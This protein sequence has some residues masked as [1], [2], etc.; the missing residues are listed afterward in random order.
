VTIADKKKVKKNLQ[1]YVNEDMVDFVNFY[2]QTVLD[3]YNEKKGSQ[4]HVEI[5][6]DLGHVYPGIKGF[7]DAAIIEPFGTLHL[8]DLKYGMRKVE[9]EH[10]EQGMFYALGALDVFP[11][12]IIEE[13]NIVIVQPRIS[14]FPS[15]WLISAEELEA[16]GEETLAPAAKAAEDSN[17]PLVT[18]DHCE[19]FFCKALKFATCPATESKVNEVIGAD[20]TKVSPTEL[21]LPDPSDLSSKDVSNILNV[22]GLITA[23]LKNVESMAK[24]RLLAGVPVPGRKLVAGKKG[25]RKW[26]DEDIAVGD[27]IEYAK[28]PTSLYEPPKLKS[29]AKME[30]IPEFKKDKDVKALIGKLVTSA[31]G[32]PTMVSDSDPRP[33]LELEAERIEEDEYEFINE[34]D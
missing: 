26:K 24:E 5:R 7:L 1:K 16:W 34:L 31:P 14:E 9:A 6:V 15:N 32:A 2:I 22:S 12:A 19:K 33:E 17:A 30:K 18:G 27:L 20:V 25:A 29:P 23:W 11:A 21:S 4:L 28:D 3:T 10:N 13:V 8:F